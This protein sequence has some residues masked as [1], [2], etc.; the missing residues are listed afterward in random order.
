MVTTFV[1]Q[2]TWRVP[3]NSKCL[4]HSRMNRSSSATL[5]QRTSACKSP[6]STEVK[7]PPAVETSEVD[8]SEVVLLKDNGRWPEVGRWN[9]LM[10]ELRDPTARKAVA[11]EFMA[12]VCRYSE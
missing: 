7:A 3:V 1:L 9:W 2:R 5:F 8:T 6:V 12:Q 11:V 4:V 10:S